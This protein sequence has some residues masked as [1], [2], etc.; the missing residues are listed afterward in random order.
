MCVCVTIDKLNAISI[1]YTQ[2]AALLRPYGL[3]CLHC[4]SAIDS[5]TIVLIV[6]DVVKVCVC[7]CCVGHRSARRDCG[8][9]HHAACMHLLLRIRLSAQLRHTIREAIAK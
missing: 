7:V 6:C 4:D 3:H 9:V 1:M 8:W 2:H 5:A